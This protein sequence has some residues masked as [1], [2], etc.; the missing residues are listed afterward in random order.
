MEM[1]TLYTQVVMVQDLRALEGF[2]A[3]IFSHWVLRL[4]MF[5]EDG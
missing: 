4:E 3:R 5:V 2:F 1:L